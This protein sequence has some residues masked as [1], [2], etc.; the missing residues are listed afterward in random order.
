MF[1]DSLFLWF[2]NLDHNIYMWSQ[3]CY[4]TTS[5][6][7]LRPINIPASNFWFCSRCF[8]FLSYSLVRSLSSHR[9][10]IFQD[11][12]CSIVLSFFSSPTCNRSY[13]TQKSAPDYR[14]EW[15]RSWKRRPRC[16]RSWHSWHSGIVPGSDRHW[17]HSEPCVECFPP[18]FWGRTGRWGDTR[19]RL[20]CT[21]RADTRTAG[22]G[23]A[24]FP[25]V[26][27][28]SK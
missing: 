22:S 2:V 28:K 19:V 3:L 8:S 7:C 13:S 25:L 17:R 26:E 20:P 23:S 14:F 24:Y 10:Y 21:D 11:I 12:I 1:Y 5:V 16:A 15:N 27:I 6:Q 18:P 9:S 4:E